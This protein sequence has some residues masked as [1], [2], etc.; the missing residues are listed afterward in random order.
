MPLF[1][2]SSLYKLAQ[3]GKIACQMVGRYRS[4]TLDKWLDVY[5]QLA[6]ATKIKEIE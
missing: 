4:E 2:R 5:P 6:A 1:P 3:E